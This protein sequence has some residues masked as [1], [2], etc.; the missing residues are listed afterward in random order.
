MATQMT[1]ILV[2]TKDTAV[3]SIIGCLDQAYADGVIA[4]AEYDTLLRRVTSAPVLSSVAPTVD[5]LDKAYS[6]GLIPQAVYDKLL[7]Y[8]VNNDQAGTQA[9]NAYL[10]YEADQYEARTMDYPAAPPKK[11]LAALGV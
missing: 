9:E 3:S 4:Q 11:Y 6:D 5:W 8:I 10:E 1:S 2:T 7:R